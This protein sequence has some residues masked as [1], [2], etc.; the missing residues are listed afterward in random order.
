VREPFAGSKGLAERARVQF[1]G[2]GAAR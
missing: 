1:P 2:M